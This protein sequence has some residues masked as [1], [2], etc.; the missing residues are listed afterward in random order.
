MA[1]VISG[2]LEIFIAH[3][4]KQFPLLHFRPY[5]YHRVHLTRFSDTAE[6]KI[7]VKT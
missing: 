6:F 5:Q 2:S 3:A 1:R 7:Q 4:Q